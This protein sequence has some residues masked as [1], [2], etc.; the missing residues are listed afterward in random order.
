MQSFK[1]R[2]VT[3]IEILIAIAIMLLIVAAFSPLYGNLQSSSQLNEA[4]A[5]I[6]DTIRR[7]REQ[8][9][10][11]QNNAAHGVY[12]QI[13]PTGD[14]QYIFYQGSSYTSPSH[15]PLYDEITTLDSV[16]SLD[17]TV[18]LNDI[19]F[20]QG[21]GMLT[22]TGTITIR[23]VVNGT[24]EIAINRFGVVDIQ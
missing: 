10:A 3:L 11:G 19:A 24:R 15:D 23:H 20:S 18:P 2:G 8:S 14:D 7:A 1:Q 17:T 4:T 16:L 6:V 21:G 9:V 13:N 5:L 22:A 12:F